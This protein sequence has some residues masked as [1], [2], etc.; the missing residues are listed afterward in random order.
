MISF[1][2]SCP[3]KYQGTQRTDQKEFVL[4]RS[5]PAPPARFVCF[6]EPPSM[7]DVVNGNK[8]IY[9]M[10]DKRGGN[11]RRKFCT[12]GT[13]FSHVVFTITVRME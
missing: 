8:N 6:A 13:N 11:L 7:R 4:T 5:C 9:I 10:D 3:V 12:A 1:Y 2:P